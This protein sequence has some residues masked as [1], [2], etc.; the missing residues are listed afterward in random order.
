MGRNNLTCVDRAARVTCGENSMMVSLGKER[1]HYFTV[2]QLRLRYASCK[3][4]ENST[5][6]LISTSLDSCGT[7]RN[8]TEDY[9]IF[10]NEV[11]ADALIIDGVV[12]R[13]HD[14]KMP[15]YCRYSRKKL[16]SL[17]FTPQRIYFGNETG[18]G[19]FTFNLDFYGNSSFATPLTEQDYPLSLALNEFVYL[20]YSVAST[21]DL[22]I[23]A[24]NCKATKDASFYSWPQYTFLQNGCPTDST[25][26]YNYS[27]TR[28]Y[29]QFKIRTHRFWNDYDIVYFHCELL[30]CHH[31]SPDS[32][33]SKGCIKNKR[34]RREV[35]R[36]V[37]D[38][39]ESTNKIILTGGPVVFEVAKEDKPLD[40][41][42]A[43]SK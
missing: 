24:E 35:T 25:L 22:V 31:N 7:Q 5:H 2:N 10:W 37:G 29:Q 26:E 39:E 16:M 12:T 4:T 33:C 8:E 36:D 9:L 34:K 32:R 11:L 13:S 15:F 14:I 38:Q 40:H 18:Y 41:R 42:R 30:A 43:K 1:F 23:M 27:P 6:F 21:A 28:H 17:A 19:S 3:A 20:Q